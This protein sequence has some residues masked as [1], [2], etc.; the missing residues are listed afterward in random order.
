MYL[1]SS[2][3]E[4]N[5]RKEENERKKFPRID[6]ENSIAVQKG[7]IKFKLDLLIRVNAFPSLK[8]T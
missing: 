2:L 3:A 1:K 6:S 8:F 5:Q 4:V 7:Q